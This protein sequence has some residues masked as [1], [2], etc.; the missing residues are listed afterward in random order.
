[1]QSTSDPQP[2]DGTT[3][4]KEEDPVVSAV[5]S[6]PTIY[7]IDDDEGARDSLLLLL[8]CED[9]KVL[10]YKNAT[11]F[12]KD[13]SA[14]LTNGCILLDLLLG[15]TH[16][17]SVHEHL[18]QMGCKLPIIYLTGYGSISIAVKS[19]RMG[20]SDFLTKPVNPTELLEKI[21][22]LTNGHRPASPTSTPPP[23]VPETS[24]ESCRA[25]S[26][27]SVLT[28]REREIIKRVFSGQNNKVI[29]RDLGISHRTVELHR[30][31]ILQ[32]TGKTNMMELA[33]I[34]F[35][36]SG[37]EWMSPGNLQLMRDL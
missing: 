3:R 32:K 37:N 22:E 2:L 15:D 26:L 23:D 28:P 10:A 13:Y 34:A 11:D 20:A 27:F 19:I 25:S 33:Q 36:Q 14:Y 8:E 7:I 6:A 4:P 17:N 1:M 12:Y 5:N 18:N 31:H 24:D 35:R 21:R 16:G 29:A 30:S 9:Y